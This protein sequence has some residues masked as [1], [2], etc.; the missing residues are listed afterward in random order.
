MFVV[1]ALF[2]PGAARAQDAGALAGAYSAP[3]PALQEPDGRYHDFMSDSADGAGRYGESMLGYGLIATGLR[4][5]DG[6]LVDSGLKAI[7]YVLAHP[8]RQQA[9]PSVFETFALAASYNLVQAWLPT[10]PRVVALTPAWQLR[11]ATEVPIQLRGG[12]PY[13]NKTVVEAVGVLELL[14]TGVHSGL[15]RAWLHDRGNSRRRVARVINRFVPR[16]I[17]QRD[18]RALLCDPP[19]CPLAYHGLALGF[20][21]RAVELLG[22]SSRRSARLTLLRAARASRAIAA[23]DGDVAYAGRSQEQAWALA[24][25]AYGVEAAARLADGREAVALRSLAALALTRLQ[26]LHPVI[27]G[28]MAIVPALRGGARAWYPGIDG[29]AGAGPYTG[30]TIAGLDLAAGIASAP[31]PLAPASAAA[32]RRSPVAPGGMAVLRRGGIW[33][34]VARDRFGTDLR[35]DSGLVALKR[36]VAP[37]QW[38]DVIPLRPRASAPSL[39]PT[40]LANGAEHESWGRRIGSS[41]AGIRVRGGFARARGKVTF[42]YAPTATGVELRFRGRPHATYRYSTFFPASAGARVVD[43]WSVGGEGQLVRAS[44]PVATTFTPG[45]ASA[46]EQDLVRADLV[47]KAGASGRVRISIA[48]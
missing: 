29:Y 36:E 17:P 20:Y 24:F 13:W 15:P 35:Y 34:A 37:G 10:D 2:A 40:L 32:A 47:F 43:A 30:L 27:K 28:G 9:N 25:T 23:P 26:T 31:V 6:R 22:S 33:M 14:R 11:L 12:R 38:R 8:E 18:G 48:G 3:W 46:I 19:A 39:G 42:T 44:A 7:A 45:F 4:N 16:R 41:R 21:A 1:V 5:G